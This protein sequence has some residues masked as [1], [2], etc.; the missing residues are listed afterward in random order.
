[1]DAQRGRELNHPPLFVARTMCPAADS[2]V[3]TRGPTGNRPPQVF[4]SP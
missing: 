3:N 1:M 4:P 2:V